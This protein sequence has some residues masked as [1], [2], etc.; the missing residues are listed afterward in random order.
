MIS[1]K[2]TKKN[3]DYKTLIKLYEKNKNIQLYLKKNSNLKDSEIIKISYDIQSGAYVN[4]YFNKFFNKQKKMYFPFIKAIN[5]FK[6]IKSIL[7]FGAGEM[8]NLSF[9]IKN[10]NQ[11]IK[12]YASDISFNRLYVGKQ[13]LQKQLKKDQFKRVK[14][15]C[16]PHLFIPLKSNSID[17]VITVHALEPNNKYKKEILSEILRVSNKGVIL[18]EPHYENANEKIK[19]R[20][21]KFNY[22]RNLEKTI[23]SLGFDLK[24]VK[25]LYNGTKHNN[26]SLFIIN[27]RFKKKNK[28][29]YIDFETKSP[30]KKIDNFYV[31]YNSKEIYPI[32]SDIF[33][34][35]N[36]EKIFLPKTHDTKY[37][38]Y[39]K[40]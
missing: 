32:L 33:V 34:S 10:L 7:D 39:F 9:F 24:V 30:L 23:K 38:N 21:R 31:S 37:K 16:N 4:K 6:N 17:L 26:S 40:N 14:Y 29:N 25:N 3:L 20:M 22:V 12:F 28:I 5:E 27:K 36:K 15:I 1:M 8:T 18:M 2:I 11:K 35:K 13:F 19:K